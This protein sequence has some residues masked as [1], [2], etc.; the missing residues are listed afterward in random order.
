MAP[1][2]P[3]RPSGR[4]R[5]ARRAALLAVLGAAC[6]GGTIWLMAVPERLRAPHCY[7]PHCTLWGALSAELVVAHHN[8]QLDW[9]GPALERLPPG[10]RVRVYSKGEVMPT[11]GVVERLP[12]VGRES[13]TFLYHV[14]TR[15]NR[16]ADI[17]LFVMGARAS[18][19]R[20]RRRPTPQQQQQ[21]QQQQQSLC[22]ARAP[23][24]PHAHPVPARRTVC[25]HAGSADIPDPWWKPVQL[26][27]MLGSWTT[28]VQTREGFYCGGAVCALPDPKFYLGSWEGSTFQ[29]QRRGG[30]GK[31]SGC[32]GRVEGRG[33]TAPA[34]LDPPALPASLPPRAC[35][36]QGRRRGEAGAGVGAPLPPLV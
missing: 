30:R 32:W 15:Y 1:P 29:V 6:C 21:Q 10:T 5:A 16:L 24:P 19:G 8:E 7:W 17:T 26:D 23:P 13:H 35:A 12:N 27:D 33:G 4:V 22:S 36:G 18:V 3:A 11:V 25:G 31:G 2:K 14:A 34:P 20:R 28:V 9:L